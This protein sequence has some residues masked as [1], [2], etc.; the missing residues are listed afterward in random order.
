MT[1]LHIDKII[2]LVMLGFETI[3]RNK[4]NLKLN[5]LLSSSH[6]TILHYK[7]SVLLFQR[8]FVLIMPCSLDG[9]S[10]FFCGKWLPWVRY[11]KWFY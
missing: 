5:E 4:M 9:P 7:L 1:F 3:E 10:E 8:L 11:I 6:P 2:K